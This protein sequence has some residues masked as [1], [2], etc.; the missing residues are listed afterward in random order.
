[1]IQK[2]RKSVSSRLRWLIVAKLT[3]KKNNKNIYSMVV[4]GLLSFSF[5]FYQKPVH[6]NEENLMY[7][8]DPSELSYYTL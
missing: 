1:M 6:N 8:K 4:L 7:V 5:I 2:V 3:V